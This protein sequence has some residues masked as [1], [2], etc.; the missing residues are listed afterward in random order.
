MKAKITVEVELPE[1][2]NGLTD[3]QLLDLIESNYLTAPHK[4]HLFKCFDSIYLAEKNKEFPDRSALWEKIA[5]DHELWADALN[6]TENT[7]YK[8]LYEKD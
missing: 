8:I 6:F 1:Y 4:Y 2:C 7:N 3:E 5:K